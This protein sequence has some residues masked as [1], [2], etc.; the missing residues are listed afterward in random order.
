MAAI[1]NAAARDIIDAGAAKGYT[2]QQ[3][4]QLARKIDSRDLEDMSKNRAGSVWDAVD[5]LPTAASAESVSA[6]SPLRDVAGQPM[7]TGRQIDYILELLER[8]A[9]AAATRPS[10]VRRPS[11]QIDG[12]TDRDAIARL[13]RKEASAYIDA[14]SVKTR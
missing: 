9:H 8:R 4:R 1:G 13:T 3:I 7:A 11:P 12:P 2:E 6:A 5:K 10:W 14:L